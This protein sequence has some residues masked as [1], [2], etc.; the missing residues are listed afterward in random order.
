MASRVG[1]YKLSKRDSA[2]SLA[3]GGTVNGNL[4]IAGN[5]DIGGSS[6]TVGFF[7]ATKVAKS[8]LIISHSSTVEGAALGTNRISGAMAVS[9]SY[10]G[11]LIN[12]LAKVGIISA[13]GE[14][15]N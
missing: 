1:K 11:E 7:G 12:Q 9:G 10:F 8:A 6:S 14:Y 15:G 5:V 13:S 4:N 2:L 3:D